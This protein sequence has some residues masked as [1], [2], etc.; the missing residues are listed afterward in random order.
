MNGVGQ[1]GSANA[2]TSI[3]STRPARVL[4]L[5]QDVQGG[6]STGQINQNSTAGG[7]S[8]TIGVGQVGP[9]PV[10]ASPLQQSV[11]GSPLVRFGASPGPAH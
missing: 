10:R 2:G 3:P 6:V 8:Q 7:T 1:A 4:P 11:I 5:Q 9:A